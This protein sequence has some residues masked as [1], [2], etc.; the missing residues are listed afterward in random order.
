MPVANHTF[1]G[2]YH[3]DVIVTAVV[4]ATGVISLEVREWYNLAG[5]TTLAV[6]DL[7]DNAAG[8]VDR[9]QFW[10]DAN[11]GVTEVETLAAER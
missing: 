6:Y 3:F 11:M 9:L 5:V 7:Q 2:T 1:A 8:A 4:P 10:V